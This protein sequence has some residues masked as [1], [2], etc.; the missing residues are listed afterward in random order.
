MTRPSG[1][2]VAEAVRDLREGRF[3]S[4]AHQVAKNKPTLDAEKVELAKVSTVIDGTAL[5][6][7]SA[8][9]AT[10]LDCI[11]PPWANGLYGWVDDLGRTLVIH[12]STFDPRPIAV[13]DEGSDAAAEVADLVPG[14]DEV[15]SG[16]IYLRS[17]MTG[18]TVAQ[19][20]GP[21]GVFFVCMDDEG[22]F[23]NLRTIPLYDELPAET[24][25][26]QVLWL[27]RLFDFMHC[28][29]IEIVEPTR[30]RTERRR[31][32]RTG[33]T[34]SEI[35]I[36]PVGK[37]TRSSSPRSPYQALM[38]LTSVRGHKAK[39]GPKYGRG[40]LFGK[41]EGEYWIPQHARGLH[42]LGEVEQHFDFE[43]E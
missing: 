35:H 42:E 6:P 12:A 15:I 22:K 40:L 39:Y 32:A 16:Y 1:E 19:T 36:R 7:G 38:P 20:K 33:I 34:V 3:H 27:L 31:I 21:F 24:L 26:V 4:P 17:I 9:R 41:Y 13:W 37:S 28:R 43:A 14:T 29:N 18:H 8:H 10:D 30:P 5:S 2:L 11:R 23:L 25:E